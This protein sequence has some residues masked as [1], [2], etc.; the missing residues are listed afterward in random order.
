[1]PS[2]QG[3]RIRRNTRIDAAPKIEGPPIAVDRR[4]QETALTLSLDAL[5]K[6]LLHSEL[7]LRLRLI[8]ANTRVITAA[9]P[10]KQAS[11]H[12]AE[13]TAILAKNAAADRKALQVGTAMPLNIATTRLS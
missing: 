2:R 11:R 3:Q 8:V 13:A 7:S 5:R 9:R 4:D 6:P 10:I 1:M 12:R